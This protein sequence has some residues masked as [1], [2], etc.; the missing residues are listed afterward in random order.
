MMKYYLYF[1]LTIPIHVKTTS[2]K[3]TCSNPNTVLNQSCSSTNYPDN[4]LVVFFMQ[5]ATM[6]LML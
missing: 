3:T 2:T 4:N 1:Y 6:H 5:Q